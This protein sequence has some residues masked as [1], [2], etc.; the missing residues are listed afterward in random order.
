MKSDNN[1]FH[2]QLNSE[3]VFTFDLVLL[4]V[5][6]FHCGNFKSNRFFG[7]LNFYYFFVNKVAQ[8]CICQ[9]TQSQLEEELVLPVD[10][11]FA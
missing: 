7:I 11:Y 4:V 2:H 5:K 6:Y 10:F 3:I 1:L 9:V 8:V